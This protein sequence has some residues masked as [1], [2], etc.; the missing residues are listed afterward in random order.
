MPLL[1]CQKIKETKQRKT[2]NSF[3]YIYSHLL[4]AQKK[5]RRRNNRIKLKSLQK[6]Q[7]L[8]WKRIW[9]KKS[10]FLW[11]AIAKSTTCFA[12]WEQIIFHRRVKGRD[13]EIKEEKTLEKKRGNGKWGWMGRERESIEWKALRTLIRWLNST[14]VYWALNIKQTT[15]Q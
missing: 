9:Q 6:A 14:I 12:M 13:S 3:I 5:G 1:Q 15:I 2:K 10:T 11:R 7:G 8:V 4:K